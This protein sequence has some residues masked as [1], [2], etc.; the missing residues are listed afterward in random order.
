ML[1]CVEYG[2]RSRAGGDSIISNQSVGVIGSHLK[3]RITPDC[4]IFLRSDYSRSLSMK[5]AN[6]IPNVFVMG[7][8]EK[9]PPDSIVYVFAADQHTHRLYV[10]FNCLDYEQCPIVANIKALY[11]VN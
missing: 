4:Q 1:Y 7:A 6:K 8:L 11:Q 2:D 10:S 9:V 5:L 3:N